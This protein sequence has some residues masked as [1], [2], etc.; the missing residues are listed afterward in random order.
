MDK[1]RWRLFMPA[2]ICRIIK[3]LVLKINYNYKK[4]EHVINFIY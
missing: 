2:T 1:K 3:Y 4:C